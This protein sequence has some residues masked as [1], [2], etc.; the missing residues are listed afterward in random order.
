MSKKDRIIACE[1]AALV[2]AGRHDY[3]FVPHGWSLAVF[4]ETYIEHGA[5]GT[6][7]DFGPKKP[8]K[9]KAIKGGRK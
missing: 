4:F 2:L 9:L 1:L 5:D 8:A 6:R 3:D 7:K